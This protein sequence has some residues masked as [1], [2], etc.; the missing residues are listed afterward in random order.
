MSKQD[1][2]KINVNADN[3]TKYLQLFNGMFDLTDM[4]L[5]VLATFIDVHERVEEAGLD[6]GPFSTEIRKQVA[7]ELGRDD[8]TT[9]NNYI[10]KLADKKAILR[11]DKGYSIHPFLKPLGE[12]QIVFVLTTGDTKQP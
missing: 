9:L 10:K 6:V 5:T 4:E 8:F 1:K 3:T 12:D 7:K 11:K 2:K